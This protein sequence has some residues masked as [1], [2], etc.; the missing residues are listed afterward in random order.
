MGIA[1]VPTF[2]AKRYFHEL[3]KL[4]SHEHRRISAAR[5]KNHILKLVNSTNN[6]KPK[7]KDM[8]GFLLLLANAVSAIDNGC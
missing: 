3:V 7:S 6:F 8:T 5:N 4:N 1:V 2:N